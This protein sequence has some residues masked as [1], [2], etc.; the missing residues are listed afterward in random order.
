MVD[1]LQALEMDLLMVLT[2]M[3]ERLWALHMGL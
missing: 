2:L 3:V 1:M